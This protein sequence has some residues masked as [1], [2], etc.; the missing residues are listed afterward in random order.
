MCCTGTTAAVLVSVLAVLLGSFASRMYMYLGYGL[1]LTY[2]D[3]SCARLGLDV[4]MVGSEDLAMGK[5]ST[6]FISS[7]DLGHIFKHGTKAAHPGAIYAM[8]LST[9][10]GEQGVLTRMQIEP[11]PYEP[12]RA[13]FTFQ[14][15]GIY[16]S[17]AT[18]R[19]YAVNHAGAESTVE[20]FQL[21]YATAGGRLL[22]LRRMTHLRTVR[23]PLFPR[24]GINDVIEGA[25][26]G[27]LYVTRW[28]PFGFPEQGRAGQGRSLAERLQ[29]A[30]YVPLALSG[31]RLTQAFRCTWDA[32][33]R[34]TAHCADVTGSNF[35]MA[36]GITIS[37]DRQTVYINDATQLAVSVY[38]RSVTGALEFVEKFD[39]PFLGDNIEYDEPS[40]D[41]LI[42]F[43]P[44]LH[45]VVAR[46]GEADP[47]KASVMPVAGGLLVARRGSDGWAGAA[48]VASFL[49]AVLTEIYLCNVCSY[50]EI[51]RRN[52]CG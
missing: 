44:L 31:L 2:N 15:H 24:Y 5:G 52:G 3:D 11:N 7:G 17:N 25:S 32:E 51:L 33:P 8:D 6:L 43:T 30:V 23:S 49:A 13:R 41:L 4:G 29:E 19:L 46:D 1:L 27:E 42:G 12:A 22:A 45:Q 20:V 21:R 38:H 40:G 34:S 50:Q 10:A 47:A 16:V 48:S 26:G 14:P 35:A 28:L 9:G 18:D 39:L 36:N 37:A